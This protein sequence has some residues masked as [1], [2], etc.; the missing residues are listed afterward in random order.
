MKYGTSNQSQSSADKAQQVQKADFKTSRRVLDRGGK[1]MISE[2]AIHIKKV[3][4]PVQS[5]ADGE[6]LHN[7]W[8]ET[9][10]DKIVQDIDDDE[11]AHGIYMLW[12]MRDNGKYLAEIIQKEVEQTIATM[13]ELSLT[14]LG[15]L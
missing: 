11:L 10:L 3:E 8:Y 1:E 15:E 14:K 6:T 12:V 9:S 4:D 13:S 7:N 2:N 5:I